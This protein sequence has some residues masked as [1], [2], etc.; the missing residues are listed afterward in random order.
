MALSSTFA[1]RSLHGD[2]CV[3]PD[4]MVADMGILAAR[5][6]RDR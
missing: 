1:S 5:D 4:L 3:R 6:S 2:M